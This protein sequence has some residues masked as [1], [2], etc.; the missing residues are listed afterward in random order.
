MKILITG[1]NG[2]LGTKLMN[3]LSNFNVIG[4]DLRSSNSM[5]LKLPENDITKNEIIKK[6]EEIRP[7]IIIHT[8]AYTDVD[9]CEI[10]KE[11]CYDVNVNGTKNI[12]E[13]AKL[14]NAKIIYIST[15]FV[16]DGKKRNYSEDDKP[17]PSIYYSKTKFE[18]EELVKKYLIIRSS[19]LYGYNNKNDNSNFVKWVI[20]NLKENKRIKVVNDQINNPTLIDDICYAITKLI[21]QTGIF[22]VTGSEA[23]SRYD[24]ALKIAEVFNL[25]KDLIEPIT[26]EELNQKAIRPKDVSLDTLKIKS[27]GINMSNIKQGLLKMKEQMEK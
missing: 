5:N 13:A 22:H 12:I 6:I 2:L 27:L 4:I 15:D 21:N 3:I 14:V 18:G 9:K 1:S 25:N 10:E 17:N 7:D 11:K 16:F 23:I 26:S 24:F 20:E 19:V 8:A